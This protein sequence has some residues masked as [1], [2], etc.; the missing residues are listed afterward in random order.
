[1][2]HEQ[3]NKRKNEDQRI[4]VCVASKHVGI[5]VRGRISENNQCS[6]ALQIIVELIVISVLS[7]LYDD[8]PLIE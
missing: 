5:R 6:F 1:M 2:I 7:H 8:A 4:R 3:R